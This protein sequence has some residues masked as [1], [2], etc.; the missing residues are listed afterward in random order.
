MRL[1]LIAI[2]NCQKRE[3]RETVFTKR[4]KL[5]SKNLKHHKKKQGQPVTVHIAQNFSTSLKNYKKRFFKLLFFFLGGEIKESERK[6]IKK[7]RHSRQSLDNIFRNM[8]RKINR[9]KSFKNK[10]K[11]KV[12]L[13]NF[14]DSQIF[15]EP[16]KKN[17]FS[18]NKVLRLKISINELF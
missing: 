1:P 18:T 16:K 3:N 15:A 5:I 9:Y 2:P 17:F 6:T 8:T 11:K 12:F 10:F 14:F 13:Q 4:L 7:I